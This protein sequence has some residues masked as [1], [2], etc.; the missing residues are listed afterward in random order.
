MN[1]NTSQTY[2][3]S[4]IFFPAVGAVDVMQLIA[5]GTLL[6]HQRL[7]CLMDVRDGYLMSLYHTASADRKSWQLVPLFRD[8]AYLSSLIP[9]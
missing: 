1:K 6:C 4:K 7:W 9:R 8:K 3:K 2:G 5:A